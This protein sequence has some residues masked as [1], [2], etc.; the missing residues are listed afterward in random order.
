M[1]DNDTLVRQLA[2]ATLRAELTGHG[3]DPE[4]AAVM[5]ARRA[6]SIT[7]TA[8]GAP[9]AASVATI[10]RDIATAAD[11]RWRQPAAE[12]GLF[13]DTLR[14]TLKARQDANAAQAARAHAALD[15][16]AGGR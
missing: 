15:R 5:A 7:R 4:Y 11:S 6:D 12:P 9:D 16:L 3:L 10:A 1:P 14:A 2:E 13:Y 8:S